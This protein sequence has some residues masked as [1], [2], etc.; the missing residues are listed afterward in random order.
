M[1]FKSSTTPYYVTRIER[2]NKHVL[3]NDNVNI[4]SLGTELLCKQR[5][6]HR[7]NNDRD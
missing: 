7:N 5:C 4:I 6:I 1:C 2:V 3:V